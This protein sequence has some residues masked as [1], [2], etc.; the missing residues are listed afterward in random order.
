M[1]WMERIYS[2]KLWSKQDADENAAAKA[3]LSN[4]TRP[5]VIKLELL[6]FD[7][8]SGAMIVFWH[9]ITH[10]LGEAL[11]FVYVCSQTIRSP[12][13]G[14]LYHDPYIGTNDAFNEEHLK[15]YILRCFLFVSH[16]CNLASCFLTSS[17]TQNLSRR[18]FKIVL[19]SNNFIVLLSLRKKPLYFSLARIKSERPRFPLISEPIDLSLGPQVPHTGRVK[20]FARP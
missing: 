2:L 18:S 14:G 17:Q 13:K 5:L 20:A 15:L 19:R 6:K 3:I 4:T 7:A 1:V 11:G 10:M 9:S 12:L 16:F 8:D